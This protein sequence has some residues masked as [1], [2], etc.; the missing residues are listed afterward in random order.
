MADSDNNAQIVS[1]SRRNRSPFKAFYHDCQNVHHSHNTVD[2]LIMIVQKLINLRSFKITSLDG[3]I[4][5][6][7]Q[8][9]LVM[10]MHF[11]K[12]YDAHHS[13]KHFL[14]AFMKFMSIVNNIAQSC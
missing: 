14:N 7:V 3:A 1:L 2:S 4:S 12:G 10:K 8:F 6:K 5:E 9:D 11:R 13:V